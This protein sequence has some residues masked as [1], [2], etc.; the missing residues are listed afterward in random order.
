[1]PRAKSNC[2]TGYNSSGHLNNDDYAIICSWLIMPS[3]YSSCFGKPG[4]TTIGQPPASKENGDLKQHTWALPQTKNESTDEDMLPNLGDSAPTPVIDEKLFRF[5]K[6]D[7][8]KREG[9]DINQPAMNSYIITNDIPLPPLSTEDI[10]ITHQPT[11]Y[12]ELYEAKTDC[13]FCLQAGQIMNLGGFPGSGRNGEETKKEVE[14]KKLEYA[15]EE[16]DKELVYTREEKEKEHELKLVLNLD[17]S[18]LQHIRNATLVIDH[19]NNHRNLFKFLALNQDLPSGLLLQLSRIIDSKSN[20]CPSETDHQPFVKLIGSII[21]PLNGRWSQFVL[22][23]TENSRLMADIWRR[24]LG[25]QPKAT[26]P[27]SYLQIR[28]MKAMIADLEGKLEF[29][30]QSKLKHKEAETV[31]LE[32]QKSLIIKEKDLN[33]KKSKDLEI[34][35]DYLQK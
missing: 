30:I 2:T 19:W 7:E 3:N 15:E 14:Y 28:H 25:Q 11:T 23:C 18:S 17:I 13:E 21:E 8:D 27:F 16:K 29:E 34:Q 35:V 26:F 22:I 1:M 5:P 9:E 20:S 4:S 31:G 33:L 12:A 32:N 10:I 6:E 24:L